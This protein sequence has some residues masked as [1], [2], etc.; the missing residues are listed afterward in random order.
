MYPGAFSCVP[1]LKN[2]FSVPFFPP[3]PF[4]LFISRALLRVS[5]QMLLIK[6]AFWLCLIK[7]LRNFFFEWEDF[8][9]LS[10]LFS[11][12]LSSYHPM[13]LISVICRKVHQELRFPSS[14]FETQGR[15]D[16]FVIQRVHELKFSIDLP[17]G[18]KMTKKIWQIKIRV[19]YLPT[20]VLSYFV[21]S[22]YIQT[23]RL[24]RC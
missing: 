17:A 8:A 4:D 11:L 22:R 18:Q 19:L 9:A 5:L 23:F 3:R 21:T 20:L 16:C 1:I 10:S 13:A 2:P 15:R 6:V 12:P 24:Q 14:N 7:K